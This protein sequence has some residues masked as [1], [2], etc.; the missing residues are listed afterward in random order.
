MIKQL[1]Y[2]D[3]TADR[4]TSAVARVVVSRLAVR[5]GTP[6]VARNGTNFY[7]ALISRRRHTG[8]VSAERLCGDQPQLNAQRLLHHVHPHASS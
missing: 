7:V 3:R 6:G 5:H 4:F 1:P 8:V 2:D